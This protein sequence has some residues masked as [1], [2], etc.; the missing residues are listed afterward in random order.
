MTWWGLKWDFAILKTK[1]NKKSKT[2]ILWKPTSFSSFSTGLLPSAPES[3]RKHQWSRKVFAEKRSRCWG[4]CKCAPTCRRLQK[5]RVWPEDNLAHIITTLS[6]IG[7]H[8]AAQDNH[9][10]VHQ[11]TISTMQQRTKG[12]QSAH[13]S[14]SSW[15]ACLHPCLL[16][17][18]RSRGPAKSMLG[19]V[20]YKWI[21]VVVSP[22]NQS[23]PTA[24]SSI[25]NPS[26]R[27]Y[28]RSLSDP[29]SFKMFSAVSV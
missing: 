17:G 4:V 12:M 7:R 6:T 3:P 9:H 28:W 25:N 20:C 13:G 1:Q 21:A 16:R 23:P 8:L 24:C 2:K 15:G 5:Q 10:R 11:V 14:C 27:L 22:L 18:G 26:A 29:D 19:S